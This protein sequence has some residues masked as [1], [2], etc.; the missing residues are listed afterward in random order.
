M[1]HYP[2]WLLPILATALTFGAPA[3]AMAAEGG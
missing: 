1:S 2:Y 3:R